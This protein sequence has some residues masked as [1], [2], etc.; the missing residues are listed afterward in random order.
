M[1][2]LASKTYDSSE[3]A[4]FKIEIASSG[5]SKCRN[6]AC[7]GDKKTI[8]KGELRI[9]RL[10]ASPT[11]ALNERLHGKRVPKWV[12]LRCCAPVILREAV[13]R[14]GGIEGVP[15]YDA[16]EGNKIC[17]DPKAEA[18]ALTHSI[19]GIESGS[20][21]SYKSGSEKKEGDDTKN[22]ASTKTTA[23]K[24][25]KKTSKEVGVKSTT[26]KAAARKEK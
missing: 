9:A 1:A 22:K 3:E 23:S 13:D 24:K 8:R 6:P 5:R 26:E 19:L 25:K 2:G 21:T 11:E 15:G 16:L 4:P 7:T 10:E 17:E 14:Y 20:S 12:H 18:Q